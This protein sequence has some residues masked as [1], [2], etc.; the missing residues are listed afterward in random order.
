MAR[1]EGQDSEYRVSGV[2]GTEQETTERT[3]MSFKRNS[4]CSVSS[5]E[6]SGF[7][8]QICTMSQRSS[9]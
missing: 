9:T 6:V 1:D 7:R 3:E 2:E 8:C 4:V 5:C